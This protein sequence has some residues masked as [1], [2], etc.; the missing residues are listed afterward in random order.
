MTSSGQILWGKN[1]TIFF[2]CGIVVAAAFAAV[3][4]TVDSFLLLI[5]SAVVR[6]VYQRHVNPDAPEKS[7]RRL[8]YI[9]TTVVGVAMR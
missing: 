1:D 2:R 7:L 6:D 3:M 8:T 9:V 4:S 5:S